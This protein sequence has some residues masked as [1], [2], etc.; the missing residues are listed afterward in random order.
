MTTFGTPVVPN[1][2]F[3]VNPGSNPFLGGPTAPIAGV[4][5]MNNGGQGF[6]QVRL[7]FLSQKAR[8]SGH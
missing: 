8:T 5:Q 7:I 6:G 4:P 2:S 3:G 1:N